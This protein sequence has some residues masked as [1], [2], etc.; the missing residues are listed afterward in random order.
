MRQ[1]SFKGW[2]VFARSARTEWPVPE[3]IR[4]TR[5]EAIQAWW[6]QFLRNNQPYDVAAKT[7]HE[8]IADGSLR[9]GKIVYHAPERA[10]AKEGDQP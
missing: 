7:W 2:A 5:R 4:H 6:D 1:L 10:R 8:R 9:V 3:T